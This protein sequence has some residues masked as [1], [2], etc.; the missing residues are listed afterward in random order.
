MSL[1]WFLCSPE[2]LV[3]YL[4]F[5]EFCYLELGLTWVFSLCIVF[6]CALPAVSSATVFLVL[7][8]CGSPGQFA[9]SPATPASPQPPPPASCPFFSLRDII[10]SINTP[11]TVLASVSAFLG[12]K[13]QNL[14]LN[15]FL[16]F[17]Q[18]VIWQNHY[19]VDLI[20]SF[21]DF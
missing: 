1:R 10:L 5:F 18:F 3:T 14:K 20:H 11:R 9:T 7:S 16:F 17:N 12:S 13:H 21:G 6:Q 2:L 4:S 15:T 19:S 8:L